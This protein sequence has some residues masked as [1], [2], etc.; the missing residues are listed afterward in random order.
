MFEQAIVVGS[1]IAGL[2]SARVLADHFNNV[3]VLD[4]DTIPNLPAI[5]KAVPQ[6]NHLHI[7]LPGGLEILKS[8]FPNRKSVV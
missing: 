6:G 2:V 5:R 3:I 7:L 1:G 8:L 4:S